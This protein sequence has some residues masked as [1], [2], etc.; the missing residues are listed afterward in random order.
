MH[1][2]VTVQN[3][4]SL[5]YTALVDLMHD[6]Y[7]KEVPET[8]VDMGVNLTQI[9]ELMIFFSNQYAFIIELWA[10]MVHEVRLLKRASK[11]KAVID[12]AMDKRDYLEKVMSAT[13]LKYFSTSRLLKHHQNEMDMRY[14]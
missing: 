13:K 11:E 9:E 12:Q 14:E 8:R 5:E 2:I 4:R 7:T 6:I 3:V 10:T 1:N